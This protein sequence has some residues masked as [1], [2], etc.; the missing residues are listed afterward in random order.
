[1]DIAHHALAI[2]NY[3]VGHAL[4]LIQLT[5]LAVDIEEYRKSDG[6]GLE[7]SRG[8]G[9]IGLD[10]DSYQG[11]ALVVVL[12]IQLFQDRHLLTAG[13]TPAGPEVHQHDLALQV[14]ETQDRKSTRL[15]S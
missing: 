15:N 13:A 5:D 8:R 9:R 7:P 11:D 2:E 12:V 4:H 3:R 6:R 14:G 1:M 10:V